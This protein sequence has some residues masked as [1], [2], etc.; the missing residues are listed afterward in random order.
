MNK[1][2]IM[3]VCF[4][5][6]INYCY[7]DNKNIQDNPIQD[8]NDMYEKI[9]TIS[10]IKNKTELLIQ[11]ADMYNQRLKNA[12]SDKE[13]TLLL[14]SALWSDNPRL[15]FEAIEYSRYRSSKYSDSEEI[16]K[17]ALEISDDQRASYV[18]LK[19]ADSG[20]KSLTNLVRQRYNKL[21]KRDDK[22]PDPLN[23]FFETALCKLGE[24]EALESVARKLC[25]EDLE[26]VYNTMWRAKEIRRKE[27]VPYVAALMYMRHGY[28]NQGDN[29]VDSTFPEEVL[30]FLTLDDPPKEI[31]E[32]VKKAGSNLFIHKEYNAFIRTI[33]Y[34]GEKYS[35]LCRIYPRWWMEEK[36]RKKYPAFKTFPVPDLSKNHYTFRGN[37]VNHW[38]VD[39]DGNPI[40]PVPEEKE[41]SKN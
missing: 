1:Y 12:K 13:R 41:K 36:N 21:K 17:R 2:I 24:V 23:D 11:M 3:V 22:Y 26:V 15:A 40:T 8:L 35:P 33:S 30:F 10:D 31:A 25:G 34:E 38:M 7:S 9:K 16:L 19:I 37:P 6:I 4:T 14:K 28:I 20:I 39:A 5:M 27:L 32:E 18:A 29:L